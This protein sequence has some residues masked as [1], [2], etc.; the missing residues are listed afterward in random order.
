[1][2]KTQA[3]SKLTEILARKPE[4]GGPAK[5]GNRR[6]QKLEK[7][8]KNYKKL[9]FELDAEK[10]K[11][12]TAITKH[13]SEHYELSCKLEELME[14]A[15]KYELDLDSRDM[16]IE[17]LQEKNSGLEKQMKMLQALVPD[18]GP[19][20]E[21]PSMFK[22]EG[23][24]SIPERKGKKKIDWKR[25]Y[26]VVSARKILFYKNDADKKSSAPTMTLDISKL[27][28]VRPV[29]QSDILRAEARDIPKIFQILY[30]NE[31]EMKVKEP[32][33]T[34]DDKPGSM[35]IPHKGH[36][37]TIC[38]YHTPVNCN[39]CQKPMWNVFNPP[40]ALECPRCHMKCHKEHVDMET[41]TITVCKVDQ[42]MPAKDLLVMAETV[43]LQQQWVENLS[44]KIVRRETNAKKKADQPNPTTISR[45]SSQS[46]KKKDKSSNAASRSVSVTSTHSIG[47]DSAPSPN[48]DAKDV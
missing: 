35:V 18:S 12:H 29:T 21:I 4:I 33:E 27:Y 20:P 1:V 30:E 9:E 46:A 48:K 5:G 28:H 37:F 2:L 22:L 34:E 8:E 36:P 42:P 44:K 7:M 25:Q 47:S 43:E 13:Q 17:Q 14:Q 40:P 11:H 19:G 6:I 23:W 31:A 26:V 10:K 32:E 38:Y 41:D 24:L 3:V 15:K 16:N 39:V 45:T